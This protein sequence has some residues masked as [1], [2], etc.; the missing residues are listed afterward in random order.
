LEEV[1]SQKR[2]VLTSFPPGQHLL[3][4][5][6]DGTDPLTRAT[7]DISGHSATV[8]PVPVEADLGTAP[9][10]EVPAL[11]PFIDHLLGNRFDPIEVV[12]MDELVKPTPR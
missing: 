11:L 10:P 5:V 7:V 12:W 9:V 3:R 4:F 6:E 1:L 8:Q 2:D